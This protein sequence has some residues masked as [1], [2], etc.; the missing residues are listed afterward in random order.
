MGTLR[1]GTSSTPLAVQGLADSPNV[2]SPNGDGQAD[3]SIVSFA[4]T[5][6]ATVTAQVVD[7]TEAV[8]LTAVDGQRMQP[9]RQS[10]AIDGSSLA[11]GTYTVVVRALGDDG[12]E[13]ESDV[14]LVVSRLLGTVT[15]SPPAFSPN[16][17]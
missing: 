1:A 12:T 8:V 4:L 6:A 16:G 11:D 10:I 5:A 7:S 15:V 14:T 9:G 13:I 17:D 2:I 3:V